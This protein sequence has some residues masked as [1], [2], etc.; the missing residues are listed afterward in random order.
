MLAQF[1]KSGASSDV[2]DHCVKESQ[3]V[4]LILCHVLYQEVQGAINL[5]PQHDSTTAM[6]DAGYSGKLHSITS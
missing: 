2:W 4:L 6:L 3:L 1:I 5:L